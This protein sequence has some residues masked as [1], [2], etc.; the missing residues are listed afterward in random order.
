MHEIRF[1]AD[2]EYFY[3]KFEFEMYFM[4]NYI[5]V[6]YAMVIRQ[7]VQNIFLWKIVK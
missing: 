2:K 1:S 4:I 7:I 3:T 5:N 6:K